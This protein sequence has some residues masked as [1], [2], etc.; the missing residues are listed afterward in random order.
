MTKITL[1]LS[2]SSGKSKVSST[3]YNSL[4][5]SVISGSV[6]QFITVIWELSS[7]SSAFSS[8]FGLSFNSWLN[9]PFT[10]FPLVKC[11]TP[12]PLGKLLTKGP[13]KYTPL[14]KIHLPF[15]ILPWKYDFG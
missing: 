3:L 5:G 10:M 4:V 14:G 9:E 8:G 11:H 15:I 13:S 7:P 1:G 12:S 2:P 6:V